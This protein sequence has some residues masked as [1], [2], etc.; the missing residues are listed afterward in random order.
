MRV[1][2]VGLLCLFL[3]GCN[4]SDDTSDLPVARPQQFKLGDRTVEVYSICLNGG[5]YYVTFVGEYGFF[6]LVPQMSTQYGGGL[7]PCHD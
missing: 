6:T 3:L 1:F 7:M 5:S 4:S 2:L